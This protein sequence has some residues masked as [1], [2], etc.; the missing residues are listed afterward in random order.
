[1]HYRYLHFSHLIL[2]VYTL[3]QHKIF[4]RCFVLVGISSLCVYYLPGAGKF[5]AS[6]GKDVVASLEIAELSDL[7]IDIPSEFTG[8]KIETAVIYDYL[9]NYGLKMGPKLK[10]L[11]DYWKGK[12]GE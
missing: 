5:E 4:S 1:M 2:Y 3:C 6:D 8:D 9:E 10:L 11:K 7:K 12:D